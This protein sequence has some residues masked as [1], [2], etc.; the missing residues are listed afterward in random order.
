MI[1][2]DIPAL[3]EIAGEQA[4]YIKQRDKY[5]TIAGRAIKAFVAS[6]RLV[7]RKEIMRTYSWDA[8]FESKIKPL[9]TRPDKFW[10]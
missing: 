2:N 7:V 4:V 3:R 10:K 5:E 8:I 9:V 1:L 6:S